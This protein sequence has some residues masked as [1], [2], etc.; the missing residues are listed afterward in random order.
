LGQ[1]RATPSSTFTASSCLNAVGRIT[2]TLIAV[3]RLIY[4]GHIVRY[5]NAKIVVGIGGAA[6]PHVIGRSRRNY[7][8]DKSK[9]GDPD[10]AWASLYYDTIVQDARTL[11]DLVDVV[12]SGW[13]MVGSDRPFPIRDPAPVKIVEATALSG[14]ERTAIHHVTTPRRLGL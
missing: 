14:A 1:P 2:D 6:L 8:L 4:A 9:L 7:E 13:I 5:A 12:G 10:L 3:S 11:R